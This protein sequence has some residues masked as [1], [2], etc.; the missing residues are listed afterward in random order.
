MPDDQKKSA[1]WEKK[2]FDLKSMA[3]EVSKTAVAAVDKT[4]ELAAK[5][6]A[7]ILGAVDQNGNGE[8]DIEDV[9]IMGLKVPGIRIN[10]ANFLQKE[11][12]KNFPQEVINDAIQFNPLHAG[13]PSK[14][15]DKIADEVIKYE[16]ACVSGIS[17]AL[18]MPGGVAMAATIPAD[19]AQY[20]AY[21]VFSIHQFILYI[22]GNT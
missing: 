22:K 5:S 6:Q 11:L 16:R 20:Y 7:A 12:Q 8:I 14:E 9:I 13:I 3:G 17:T 18:G 19:I 1:G 21:R 4:K 10:R 2:T 15:I